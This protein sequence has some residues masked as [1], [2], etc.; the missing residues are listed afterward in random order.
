MNGGL[1]EAGRR[2]R[3]ERPTLAQ[4]HGEEAKKPTMTGNLPRTLE[5]RDYQ[6]YDTEEES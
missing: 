6:S 3:S 5:R 1:G 4:P 2:Q